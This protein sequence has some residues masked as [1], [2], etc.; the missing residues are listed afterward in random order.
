[1]VEV[2]KLQAKKE[3]IKVPIQGRKRQTSSQALIPT[4]KQQHWKSDRRNELRSP[5][6]E[7]RKQE[8]V[9]NIKVEQDGGIYWYKQE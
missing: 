9:S 3:R 8:K 4:V 2:I 7:E 1:M 5:K 6:E